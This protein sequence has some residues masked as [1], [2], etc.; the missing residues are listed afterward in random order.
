MLRQLWKIKIKRSIAIERFLFFAFQDGGCYIFKMAVKKVSKKLRVGVVFGGKSVEHEVS[1]VSARNIINALNREKYKV[2]PIYI[3]RTGNWQLDRK[4]F[5]KINVVFPV[6]HGAYGE[7]GT[8]QGLLKFSRLPFV[9]AGVLGSAIGMDKDISKRLLEQAGI[10][11]ADFI[12]VYSGERILYKQASKKLGSVMFVKPANSGS[13]VGIN[14][15]K[16]EKEFKK[17]VSEAFKYD[18]KIIIEEAINGKEIECAVLGND[19][20]RASIPGEIIPKGEFYSYEA[21]YIDKDGAGLEIPAKLSKTVI[22]K[23][24]QT[25]IR[26]FKILNCEG[27]ARVDFFL[28]KNGDLLVNEINTIPGFTSISMYPKL[29]EASGISLPKLLDKLIGLALE[30]FKK[31]RKLCYC[32]KQ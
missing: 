4:N 10:A 6:I 20:P 13:S 32:Y 5:N 24:Q 1:V 14:K 17:A 12:T 22:K 11:V 27:M 21:K 25:A 2:I 8:I 18:L 26:A 31:E 30:R 3:K 7:D 16:N 29:W 15:A 23:I 9:G 28:K 19:L